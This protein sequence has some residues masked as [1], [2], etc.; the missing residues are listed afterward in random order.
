MGVYG[1]MACAVWVDVPCHVAS[2]LDE[3]ALG[4]VSR[5][6]CIEYTLASGVFS[7]AL[8]GRRYGD[9]L[10]IDRDQCIHSTNLFFSSGVVLFI[11]ALRAVVIVCKLS[12]GISLDGQLGE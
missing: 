10:G 4:G 1:G 12:G 8:V 9:D 3:K 6:T 7:A 11:F 5:A 2:T